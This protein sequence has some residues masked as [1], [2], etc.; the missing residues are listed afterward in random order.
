MWHIILYL[1]S[2]TLKIRKTGNI[3][4]TFPKFSN[5]ELNLSL[6]IT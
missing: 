1:I 6:C 2:Y 4:K 5:A 3:D